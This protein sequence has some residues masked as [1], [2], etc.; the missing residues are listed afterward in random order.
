MAIIGIYLPLSF[1]LTSI[2]VTD[3]DQTDV[4][5]F[6]S[7]GFELVILSFAR[8]DEVFLRAQRVVV[9]SGGSCRRTLDLR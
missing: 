4:N 1:R 9:A 5:L 8:Y 7:H 3:N 6:L 2:D